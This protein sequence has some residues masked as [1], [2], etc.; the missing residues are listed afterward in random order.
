M[1]DYSLAGV[2]SRLA[3]TG[4][5]LVVHRFPSGSLGLAS[6]KMRLRE[7]LFPSFTVAVCVAPG[8]TLR[9]QNIPQRLQKELDVSSTETV[10]FSQQTWEAYVHR[11][12]VRFSNGQQVSLQ[13]LVCG[14][15][16]TVLD[17]GAEMESGLAPSESVELTGLARR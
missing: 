3:Q 11:D 1:C 12:S 17:T 6:A 9:L 16:V 7:V 8:A 10:T 2:S 13:Q 15:R 5:Q 4:D 14:Q